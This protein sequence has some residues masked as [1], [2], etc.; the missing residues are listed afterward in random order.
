M[1]IINK[2]SNSKNHSSASV[3]VVIRQVAKHCWNLKGI[4]E[5]HKEK[6]HCLEI[7]SDE[8]CFYEKA[9]IFIRKQTQS[10]VKHSTHQH[11]TVRVA[12]LPDIG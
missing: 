7:Y 11:N 10:L 3:F 4:Y 9:C 12:N 2:H 5:N 6:Q 1:I 8:R